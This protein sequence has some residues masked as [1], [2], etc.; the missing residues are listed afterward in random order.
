MEVGHLVSLPPVGRVGAGI[1]LVRFSAVIGLGVSSRREARPRPPRRDHG[2]QEC[3]RVASP[4]TAASSL[5]DAHRPPGPRPRFRRVGSRKVG[6]RRGEPPRSRLGARRA[7]ADA[8]RGRRRRSLRAPGVRGA[9]RLARAG[10]RE[11]ARVVVGVLG[12]GPDRDARA[13]LPIRPAARCRPGERRRPGLRRRRRI[14]G[15]RSFCGLTS[16]RS[17][18]TSSRAHSWESAARVLSM[19]PI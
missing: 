8:A 2:S 6:I 14:L 18:N 10:E 11:V 12:R 19:W 9:R 4:A 13:A 1:L 7:R 3:R 17:S 5:R 16:A 15:D